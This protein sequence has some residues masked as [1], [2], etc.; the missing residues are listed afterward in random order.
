MSRAELSESQ[1]RIVRQRE[2]RHAAATRK[3]MQNAAVDAAIQVWYQEQFELAWELGIEFEDWQRIV[4]LLTKNVQ[5][6]GNFILLNSVAAGRTVV[7]DAAVEEAVAAP[8]R[9]SVKAA[10]ERA[11]AKG[12]K[13]K[14]Q[15]IT[16]TLYGADVTELVPKLKAANEKAQQ[17]AADSKARKEKT[18][19]EKQQRDEATLGAAC[20]KALAGSRL[21]LKDLS[22]L[23]KWQSVPVQG[24]QTKEAWPGLKAKWDA[25]KVAKEVL[26]MHAKVSVPVAKPSTKTATKKAPKRKR[27]AESSDEES[28][29]EDE[30][31]EDEDAADDD[32]EAMEQDGGEEDQ[33]D[34]EEEEEEDDKDG[35]E[36]EEEE[37]DDEEDDEESWDVKCILSERKNGKKVEYQVEWEGDEWA[38]KPTWEPACNIPATNEALVA[39][40]ARKQAKGK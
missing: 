25:C 38:G 31:A 24:K 20:G 6:S 5:R 37:D 36:E 40:L 30:D 9:A 29:D 18:E 12:E 34:G 28:S 22:A 33:K 35:E 7:I 1:A 32:G 4:T 23:L 16:Q 13:K 14:E 21:S 8:L 17:D 26:R 11:D 27:A 10:K 15:S 19:S 39:W 2:A 3:E